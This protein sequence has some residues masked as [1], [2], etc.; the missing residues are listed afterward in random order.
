MAL[1]WPRHPGRLVATTGR[2]DGFRA[3]LSGPAVPAVGLGA[4]GNV[5]EGYL[6]AG[7]GQKLWASDYWTKIIGRGLLVPFGTGYGYVVE[8]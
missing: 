5:V 2:R 4:T 1:R 8:R 6:G 7:L 3:S